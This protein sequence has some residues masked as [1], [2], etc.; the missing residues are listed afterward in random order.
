MSNGI[1]YRSLEGV[2][3]VKRVHADFEKSGIG[4]QC[5]LTKNFLGEYAHGGTKDAWMA[6]LEAAGK[7]HKIGCSE[8][9]EG[10]KPVSGIL[11]MV[12]ETVPGS[13]EFPDDF[14]PGQPVQASWDTPTVVRDSHAFN[15]I[16][17]LRSEEGDSVTILCD[18]PE[19]S[20]NCAVEVCTW[21]TYYQD[22]RFTWDT[23]TAALEAAQEVHAAAVMVRAANGGRWGL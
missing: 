15:L 18:N 5:D 22:K 17:D 14:R 19:G 1:V 10:R 13:L 21:W 4:V 20:P 6:W 23:L 2:D 8:S 9:K 7:Y 12:L 3:F 11:E 16:L